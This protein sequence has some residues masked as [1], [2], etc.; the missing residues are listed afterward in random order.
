MP[1]MGKNFS[2]CYSRFGNSKNLYKTLVGSHLEYA[3]VVWT[4]CLK[5]DK[6]AIG[7]VQRRQQKDWGQLAI[8]Y[9]QTD[10]AKYGYIF[11]LK[12]N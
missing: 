1:A 8:F 7:N 12:T 11:R 4:L 5:R 10:S 2:F 6:I 3:T 9:M